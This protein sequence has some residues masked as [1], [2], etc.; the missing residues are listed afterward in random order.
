MIPIYSVH[1]ILPSTSAVL[2]QVDVSQ[3]LKPCPTLAEFSSCSR[4]A[5]ME[6]WGLEMKK[7]VVSDKS[8]DQGSKFNIQHCVYIG[9]AHRPILC[10]CW[11]ML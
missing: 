2:G 1:L 11:I 7:N 10:F 3:L 9:R 5:A 4:L 8:S 6:N